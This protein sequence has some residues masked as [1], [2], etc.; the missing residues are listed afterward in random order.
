MR[1]NMEVMPLGPSVLVSAALRV[2]LREGTLPRC[3]HL[4]L[5]GF[6]KWT[7]SGKEEVL[8]AAWSTELR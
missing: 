5:W 1:R 7:S 3:P 8:A 2:G 4:V 6:E